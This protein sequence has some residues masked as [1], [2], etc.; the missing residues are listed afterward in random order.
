ATSPKL[1]KNGNSKTLLRTDEI[2]KAWGFRFSGN[3]FVWVKLNS[4]YRI[5]DGERY[6]NEESIFKGMGYG[7]R[8]TCEFCL[9]FRIGTPAR[10]DRGVG[11]VIILPRREHSR[12]PEEQYERIERFC[13]G[14]R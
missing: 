2:A 7:T 5:I 13:E 11:E 12:K 9:L 1:Y 3:G 8:K 14:P 4:K 10:L 6:F